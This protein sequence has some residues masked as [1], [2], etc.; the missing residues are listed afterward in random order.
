MT[1]LARTLLYGGLSP[2]EFNVIRDDIVEENHKG[3]LLYTPI[4]CIAFSLLSVLSQLTPGPANTNFWIYIVSCLAMAAFMTVT[5]FLA[6]DKASDHHVRVTVLVYTFMAVLYTFSI[7]VSV[8]HAEYPAV[9]AIAFLLVAPLLFVDRPIRIMATTILAVAAICVTSTCVKSHLLAIDD[10]W[11]AV[12]FGLVTL[13]LDVFIQKMRLKQLY[14]SR[15]ITY[16]SEN[17]TL[18]GLKNRNSYEKH[19]EKYPQSGAKVLVCAYA[20]ANGLREMNN[21]N[22]H[23]AGDALLRAIAKEMRKSFGKKDT[24]RIGGDEFVAIIPNGRIDEVRTKLQR[25]QARLDTK[26]YSVSCGAASAETAHVNMRALVRE[27]E[28][29]MY[30]QKR[31]YHGNDSV[32]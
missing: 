32:W 13:S 9:T 15:I 1:A 20:D 23:D 6:R 2:E 3:L 30:A 17:D 31:E 24:Y 11:N 7:A 16:L 25:M 27:A 4:G 28:K 18:T 10:T 22:G 5:I 19:L 12:T 21:A 8:T 26:G 14:Q 29:E